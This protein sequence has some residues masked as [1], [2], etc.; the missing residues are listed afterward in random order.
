[1]GDR[2]LVWSSFGGTW[3]RVRVR[4][5]R[6]WPRY[7]Q[8]V[9]KLLW[10]AAIYLLI[11]GILIRTFGPDDRLVIPPLLLFLL[12]VYVLVRT[13]L[14]LAL[15][16]TVTGEVLWV[17][18]WKSR[19]QGEDN[20]SIPWLEH[21]AVDE[22]KSDRTVAW[23]LPSVWRTQIRDGD[24]VTITVR[25]WSRRVVALE[26]VG[27][28]RSRELVETVS[29]ERTGELT[30]EV[31]TTATTA[32]AFRL[33]AP[34]AAGTAPASG[35]EAPTAAGTAPAFGLDDVARVVGRPVVT[36]PLPLGW[37]YRSAGPDRKPLLLVQSL[38]GLPG[39]VAW[40]AN[41]R[42]TEMDGGF[43][44]GDRAAF[45]RD[46][47]TYVLTLLGDGKAGRSALPWLVSRL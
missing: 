32:P 11:G 42:G 5:P 24:T 2:K 26:P 39:R 40:R 47:T 37:Q 34:A 6:F 31:L 41:S 20:P 21:V 28:G 8:T 12:G 30:L 29:S 45:R 1:M 27:R 13:L 46:E 38:S 33:E 17:S 22:G 3:H 44:S 14:D 35:L 16:R 9:P 23:G 7:G 10:R 43:Y 15:L 36:E 18:T 19:S 25:P 4:Y